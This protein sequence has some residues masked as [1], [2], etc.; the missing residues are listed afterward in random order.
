MTIDLINACGFWAASICFLSAIVLAFL[1]NSWNN[2][3]DNLRTASSWRAINNQ[4]GNCNFNPKKINTG[5]SN[6]NDYVVQFHAVQDVIDSSRR[7]LISKHATEQ[8][9]YEIFIGDEDS[10]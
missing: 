10:I 8:R 6:H 5:L 4:Y 2:D 3:K 7:G 9:L 1:N